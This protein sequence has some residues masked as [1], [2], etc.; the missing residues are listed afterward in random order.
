MVDEPPLNGLLVSIVSCVVAVPFAATGTL[1]AAKWQVTPA[2]RDAQPKP[3]VSVNPPLDS[4]V[5]VTVAFCVFA[6][7]TVAGVTVRLKPLAVPERLIGFELDGL[8]TAFPL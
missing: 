3:M 7:L 2:G 6:T 5:T 1:Y 4:S 8:S